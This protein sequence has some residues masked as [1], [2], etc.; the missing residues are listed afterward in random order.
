VAPQKEDVVA[1]GAAN[2]EEVRS[3]VEGQRTELN[4]VRRWQVVVPCD[5]RKLWVL[6]AGVLPKNRCFRRVATRG[7]VRWVRQC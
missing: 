1:S 6:S 2:S 7:A 5:G 4:S 3:C